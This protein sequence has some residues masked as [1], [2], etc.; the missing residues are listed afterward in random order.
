M[1]DFEILKYQNLSYLS[2]NDSDKK[3]N[4]IYTYYLQGNYYKVLKETKNILNFYK[5]DYKILTLQGMANL[6]IGNKEEAKNNIKTSYDINNKFNL[7]VLGMADCYFMDGEYKKA[8]EFYKKLFNSNYNVEALIKAG[9]CL[10]NIEGGEKKLAKLNKQKDEI[11]DKAF[12]IYYR[13]SNDLFESENDKKK[14]FAIKSLA[15]NILNPYTYNVLLNLDYKENNFTNIEKMV[16]R[17]LF[18]DNLNAEY[19]YFS[20]L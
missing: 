3:Y 8:Y 10:Q 19:S 9:L 14:Q 5:N 2:S 7:T 13:I 11:D 15:I 6:A 18:S 17:L 16:Y 12:Y 20:A 1:N 4:Q